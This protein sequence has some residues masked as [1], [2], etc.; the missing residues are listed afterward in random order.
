MRAALGR[1]K[2]KIGEFLTKA[3]KKK[4][5]TLYQLTVPVKPVVKAR[6]LQ[7]RGKDNTCIWVGGELFYDCLGRSVHCDPRVL[8]PYHTMVICHFAILAILDIILC[9][10]CVQQ[11]PRNKEYTL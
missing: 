3:A 7:Q 2:N 4:S 6:E 10:I 8:R 5:E 11:K 1:K 9:N